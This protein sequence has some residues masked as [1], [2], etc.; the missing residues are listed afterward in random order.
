MAQSIT[1][2]EVILESPD[3]TKKVTIEIG[4]NGYLYFIGSDG[5]THGLTLVDGE[6]SPNPS[7]KP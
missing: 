6:G 1:A 3:G 4:D 5:V 2:S 7:D